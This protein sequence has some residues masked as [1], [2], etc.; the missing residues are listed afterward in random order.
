MTLGKR[1]NDR[2]VKEFPPSEQQAVAELLEKYPESGEER[3]RWDILELSKGSLEKVRQYVKA[4]QTDPRDVMY[5][6]EYYDTDPMLQG[7]D[8]KKMIEDLLK[9]WGDKK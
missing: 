7:R 3:V 8:P 5:W 2:I 4:A 6:A 9:K 1:I